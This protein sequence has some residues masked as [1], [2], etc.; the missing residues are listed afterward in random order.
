MDDA[1]IFVMRIGL[2]IER[3]MPLDKIKLE[4][5]DLKGTTLGALHFVTNLALFHH[6][7]EIAFFLHEIS[8][9]VAESTLGKKAGYV[10][11]NRN[12]NK[13][14]KC[15][16]VAGIATM[17]PCQH[18]ICKICIRSFNQCNCLVCSKPVLI[19]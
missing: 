8:L 11:Q 17:I 19:S 7:D 1:L 10:V 16:F 18:K 14:N 2:M 15:G 13:C 4:L 3:Q 6:E 12:P 9:Q 5:A